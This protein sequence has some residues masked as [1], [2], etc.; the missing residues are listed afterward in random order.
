MKLPKQVNVIIVDSKPKQP[1]KINKP[2]TFLTEELPTKQ[3]TETDAVDAMKKLYEKYIAQGESDIGERDISGN[4]KSQIETISQLKT[5]L[6]FIQSKPSIGTSK[7]E[8][9]KNVVNK[10]KYYSKTMSVAIPIPKTKECYKGF[11]F[12]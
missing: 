11:N 9:K 10:K 8:E 2:E 12:K 7:K 6:S 3:L 5:L 1:L 4:V